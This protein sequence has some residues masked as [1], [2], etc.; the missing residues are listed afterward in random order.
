MSTDRPAAAADTAEPVDH[1]KPLTQRDVFELFRYDRTVR[2]YLFATLGALTMVFLVTLLG[3]GGDVPGSDVGAVLILLLGVAGLAF[4]WPAGPPLIVFLVFYF[5]LF[6]FGLPDPNDLFGQSTRVRDSHFRV[7]DMVLGLAVLV[8]VR[9]QYRIL[10]LIHQAVPFESPYRRRGEHPLR[11]PTG[12][13]AAGELGWLL[14]TAVA[15]VA[16]GQAVWWLVNALDY[17]PADEDFP[18]RW[19]DTRSLTRYGKAP[20]E[21]GEY[22]P[23]ASRFYVILAALF[24][25]YLLV[26]LVFGYWRLRVMSAAEAA[27]LLADANW[28]ETHRERVRLE[29]WRL[30]GLRRAEG[31]RRR[32]LREERERA[33]KARRAEARAAR[34][35]A[36]RAGEPGRRRRAAD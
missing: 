14:G 10:G 2:P 7:S 30:W 23:G 34:G 24:F 26:R 21:P 28:G 25:G 35:R 29:N 19:A 4:R 22:A 27:M 16:V 15:L 32:A 20:R 1:R 33:E 11:R 5:S 12:H 6:P 36:E 13:L 9:C 18:F 17:A 8:Y 31:E 3:G